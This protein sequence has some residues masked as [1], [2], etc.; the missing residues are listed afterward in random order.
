LLVDYRINLPAAVGQ[1]NTEKWV[2]Y[3]IG[4]IRPIGPD[5]FL[6]RPCVWWPSIA[7]CI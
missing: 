4:A 3:R 2:I 7:W 5:S 6:L 1:Y